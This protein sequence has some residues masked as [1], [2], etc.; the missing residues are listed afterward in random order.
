M[1]PASTITDVASTLAR[2]RQIALDYGV[3][4]HNILI[5][6]TEAMRRAANGSQMLEEIGRATNGLG[7]HVLD[8]S[9]ETL[10][11]AV[12]GSRSGLG[13]LPGGGALFLDLGGGSV[14]MTWVDTDQDQYALE[15][16]AAGISLPFGAAR[17]TRVLTQSDVHVTVT[18]TEKLRSGLVAAYTE[19]RQR[20]P[21]LK[22]LHDEYQQGKGGLVNVFMCGGGFRGYGSLLMRADEVQPFPFASVNTYSVS[23]ECFKRTQDMRK[24]N[25]DVAGKIFGMSAR[26]REQLPAIAT[27]VEAFIEA[28]P[29][30][31]RVTFCGG[32]NREGAL[33]LMLPTEVRESDPLLSLAN[34]HAA[35]RPSFDAIATTVQNSLTS[36]VRSANCHEMCSTGFMQLLIQET[37]RGQGH[38]KDSNTSYALR[39]AISRDPNV[40]GLSQRRRAMLGLIMLV[41]WGG[42]LSSADALLS[43]Q[44]QKIVDREI[45]HTSFWAFYIGA[46]LGLLA[47]IFP[48]RPLDQQALSAM[49]FVIHVILLRTLEANQG[50]CSVHASTK[51]RNGKKDVLHLDIVIQSPFSQGLDIEKLAKQLKDS[52]KKTKNERPLKLKPSITIRS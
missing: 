18:E 20:F 27:V 24:L 1:F 50:I 17:L 19:L 32:S 7:V 43:E 34:V 49:R 39:H 36:K 42:D 2:F 33:M 22:A 29:N 6:A 9:V 25:N 37:W 14:Q 38:D 28:V 13:L 12:M 8:P 23:A 11:G 3:P 52:V 4:E 40:P 10:F 15:A 44:L 45:E 26:R 5:L 21:R 46:V 51:A 47:Q 31:D 30:I 41:R 16:A 48:I 35:E